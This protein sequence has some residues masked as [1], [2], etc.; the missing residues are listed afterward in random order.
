VVPDTLRTSHNTILAFAVIVVQVVFLSCCWFGTIDYLGE[1][2]G[3]DLAQYQRMARAAP[4][5][6][7]GVPAPFAYRVAVPYVVGV[8][9][10]T[11]VVLGFRISAFVLMMFLAVQFYR[12]L[13][14]YE[15]SQTYAMVS[16]AVVLWNPYLGGYIF[17]NPFQAGD[18]FAYLLMLVALE[19]LLRKKY[20]ALAL[21][22]LIGATV[23]E[24][25]MLLVPAA[26]LAAVSSRERNKLLI[27]SVPALLVFSTLRYLVPVANTDWSLFATALDYA[28][29]SLAPVR[30]GRLLV[31]AF[32]PLSAVLGLA[33]WQHLR[34][35]RRPSVED[36]L[37][38]GIIA[39]TFL[40]GDVERLAGPALFLL[41]LR[42][43][44]YLERF[45]ERR[46]FLVVLLTGVVL[47]SL[48]FMFS[49]L[50]PFPKLVYYSGAALW[51]VL[52][53]TMYFVRS[54]FLKS[55]Q[56]VP[57]SPLNL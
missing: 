46:I 42:L 16:V 54:R 13:R 7:A 18:A 56:G 40:G 5:I 32:A 2:S 20:G 23:R 30:W 26:I 51:S 29:Y 45:F 37:G 25:T 10:P 39:S 44:P 57:T 24:T 41:L 21:A 6:D 50:A 38:V 36:L 11:D 15:A 47:C 8:L 43:R 9:F 14:L 35:M 52:L 49:Q 31:N 34:T 53:A 12:L 28:Q 17:F 19:A 48:H 1:F 33:M 22:L 55:Y 3:I 27:A 4:D